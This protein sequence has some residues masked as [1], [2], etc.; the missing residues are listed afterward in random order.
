[1]K[2]KI[3]KILIREIVPYDF[4]GSRFTGEEVRNIMKEAFDK[5]ESVILDFQGIEGIT[6][7]FGDEIVGIFTRIHGVE[8]VKNNIKLENANEKV[9]SILNWVIKYS[10]K[11]HNLSMENNNA[12]IIRPDIAFS[13]KISSSVSSSG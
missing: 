1:M 7:S 12:V 2:N 9:K 6:Q 11:I 3:R 10:K 8:F 5:G 13:Q 4:A